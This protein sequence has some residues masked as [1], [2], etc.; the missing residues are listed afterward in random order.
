MTHVAA[1][2]SDDTLLSNLTA[3]QQDRLSSMLDVYLQTL[4]QGTQ[5]A[6]NCLSQL[7]MQHPDLAD[8]FRVY[9]SSIDRLHDATAGMRQQNLWSSGDSVEPDEKRLGDYRLLREV[10]RGGMGSVYEAQQVS[11]DRRVAIKILPLASSLGEKNL[12]RFRNEAAAAAQI[13]HPNIV[14]VHSVGSESGVHFYT[15]PFI[16]GLPLDQVIASLA[17]DDQDNVADFPAAAKSDRWQFAVEIGIQAANALHAAHEV[18]VIHRDIKP[19]NLLI[20]SSEKLWIT[21]FGLARCQQQDGLTQTGDLVGTLRYMSPEQAAAQPER[22]DHRTD[23]YSL[24][25]TLYELVTLTSAFEEVSGSDLLF[26]VGHKDPPRISKL[27]PNIPRDLEAVIDKA[28]TKERDGRYVTAKALADD[29]TAVLNGTPTQARPIT[30]VRQAGRWINRHQSSVVL[31]AVACLILAAIL[32]G[33]TAFALHKKMVADQNFDRAERNFKTFRTAIDR[34]GVRLGDEL[35]G[36]PGA[37]TVRRD[38]LLET[39]TYYQDF[40]EQSGYEPDF[41]YD[42]ARAYSRMGELNEQVGQFADAVTAYQQAAGRYATLANQLPDDLLILRS[43]GLCKNNLGAALAKQDKYERAMEH[44]RDA[45]E[46]QRGLIGRNPHRRAFR[47]DLAITLNNVGQLATSLADSATAFAS[48][49]ESMRLCDALLDDGADDD[50]GV[51]GVDRLQSGQRST[52]V[53][54]SQI[55]RIQV[56]NLNNLG[57]LLANSEME[58]A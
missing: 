17:N 57:T 30:A 36:I 23:I 48:L 39:L 34:I 1:T 55:L 43:L 49:E 18:S 47:A 45:V 26:A 2:Q 29:L 41:Q 21:D 13:Q 25:A 52:V 50:R 51:G 38:M 37:E 24:G 19:S 16:D 22:I 6:A 14:P 58:R 33:V 15:M 56:A 12:A 11:L 9:V 8:T 46:H 40:V 27:C 44:Y 32:S 42:L 35:R 20:D 53:L 7:A 4:E 28:M 10:G 54:E 31:G 3:E 5:P